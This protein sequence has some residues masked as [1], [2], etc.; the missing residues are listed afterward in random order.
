MREAIL[1]ALLGGEESLAPAV[2]R[3]ALQGDGLV[4]A[5]VGT[6]VH[7]FVHASAGEKFKDYFTEPSA[8]AATLLHRD[9]QQISESGSESQNVS[10]DMLE[11]SGEH[12]SIDGQGASRIRCLVGHN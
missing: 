8:R 5:T 7:E 1:I 4:G 6:S 12:G 2:E 9:G 3:S 10:V 11:G